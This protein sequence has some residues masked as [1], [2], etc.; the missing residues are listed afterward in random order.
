MKPVRR[1]VSHIPSNKIL[2]SLLHVSILAQSTTI[3]MAQR[4]SRVG[5]HK[6]GIPSV[7]PPDSPRHRL[8]HDRKP[9]HTLLHHS[10][11]FSFKNNKIPFLIKLFNRTFAEQYF[12]AFPQ[13][14]KKKKKKIYIY[15]YKSYL[16]DIYILCLD[17]SG[18]EEK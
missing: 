17:Q 16:N 18:P 14:R 3:L 15:I 8:I 2:H 11:R 12:L 10:N 7:L 9:L 1:Y 5:R 13:T 4:N 6:N